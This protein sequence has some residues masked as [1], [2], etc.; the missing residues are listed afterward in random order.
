M[1]SILH[2]WT[3]MENTMH[4]VSKNF[5]IEKKTM[6]KDAGH[7]LIVTINIILNKPMGMLDPSTFLN[8][9]QSWHFSFFLKATSFQ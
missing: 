3:M 4:Q 8:V 5:L 1:I 6:L 7:A 2:H 9:S